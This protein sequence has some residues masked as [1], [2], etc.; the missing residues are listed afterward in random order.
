MVF[1]KHSNRLCIANLTAEHLE[2]ILQVTKVSIQTNRM[3]SLNHK[4][5]TVIWFPR[6]LV[7]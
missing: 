6:L 4:N 5:L 3:T 1:T 2:I 7:D